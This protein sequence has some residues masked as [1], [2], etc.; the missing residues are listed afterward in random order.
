MSDSGETVEQRGSSLQS[1][2]VHLTE[3]AASKQL[4]LLGDQVGISQHVCFVADALPEL[5][6]VGVT[7]LAWE[8]TNRRS[9][10]QL[11]E[12]VLGDS[13]DERQCI[14]LFLDLRGIGFT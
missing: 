10:K 9:Q 3:L 8:F 2:V 4:V 6:S 7:N 1:A 5:Y 13:W 11:D 12:L 14:D